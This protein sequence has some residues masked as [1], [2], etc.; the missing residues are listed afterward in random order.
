MIPPPQKKKGVEG[1]EEADRRA[2]WEVE[3]GWRTQMT[4]TATP[5]GIKQE[6]PI[7]P[8]TPAHLG[9]PSTALK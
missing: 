3:I 2:G 1:N 6:F 9:W 5:G 7:Y 4:V 8:R